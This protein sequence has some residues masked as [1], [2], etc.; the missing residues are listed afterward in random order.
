[1]STSAD[2]AQHFPNL[3]SRREELATKFRDGPIGALL[4]GLDKAVGPSQ[5]SVPAAGTVMG[6]PAPAEGAAPQA[7]AFGGSEVVDPAGPQ[8]TG[9][10]T[11]QGATPQA[12]PDETGSQ[13]AQSVTAPSM[14]QDALKK[15]KKPTADGQGSLDISGQ[16]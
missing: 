1:M 3:V 10:Q 9:S 4:S 15:Q 5:T 6:T 13:L 8:G 16:V 11:N 2:F 7:A 14:W 12:V